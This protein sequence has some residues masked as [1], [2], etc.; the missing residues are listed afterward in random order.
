MTT[1]LI[2]LSSLAAL[3]ITQMVSVF[4]DAVDAY[5][6]EVAT[7]KKFPDKKAAIARL[8]GLASKHEL[9]LGQRDD[10]SFIML[11]N[12]AA[13]ALL[14]AGQ[15]PE[16][17]APVQETPAEVAADPLAAHTEANKQ[18]AGTGKRGR[19]A[20]HSGKFLVAAAQKP[21]DRRGQNTG[22]ARAVLLAHIRN[23][24]G[25]TGEEAAA[26]DS[27]AL[28][29]LIRMEYVNIRSNQA[30]AQAEGARIDRK[31]VV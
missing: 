19:E 23:N 15:E 4:N 26:M 25:M 1:K 14:E 9:H 20:K 5:S 17:L 24:P 30:E 18:A 13:Q 21:K 10:G 8:E 16:E 6:L 11:S 2:A 12:A 3:S 31:S 27:A 7:V 22:S 29:A 28:G